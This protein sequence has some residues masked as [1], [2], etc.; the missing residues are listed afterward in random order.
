L[1]NFA[2]RK[3]FEIL[4]EITSSQNPLVK[5]IIELKSKASKRREKKLCII[6]GQKEIE[7]AL[8]SGIVVEKLLVDKSIE[9]I[10]DLFQDKIQ[11]IIYCSADVMDKLAIRDL[12]SKFV[13]IAQT[14]YLDLSEVKLSSNPFVLI[15]ENIE[16]P[17]NLGSLFRT[18]DAANVDL[19]ICTDMQTDLYNH[20]VIRNS[21]GCIF[22]KQIIYCSNQ[23]AF[24]FCKKNRIETQATFLHTDHYYYQQDFQKPTAIIFG[25]ESTGITDFWQINSDH[26][27]KIPM[28]GKI[29]SMNVSNSASILLYEVVRQRNFSLN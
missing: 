13:A 7:I 19:I 25:T 28:L 24:D 5:D 27:I 2:F 21:L 12:K 26:T 14:K 8:E 11:E 23:E 22:S 1:L 3:E 18:A 9:S 10:P 20:N 6:E 4:K 17:G 16:K 29:D 15:L